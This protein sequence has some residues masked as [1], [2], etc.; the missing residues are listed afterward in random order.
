MER[1]KLSQLKSGVVFAL[2]GLLPGSI[3]FAADEG[4]SGLEEIYVTASKRSETLQDAGM[5][6]TALDSF[7]LER[8]GANTFLDF[9]VRVPNLG[10]AYEADGRFDSNSPAIRGVFGTDTT[11]FY[12]DD[13]P[14][15]ASILPRVMDLERIEVLRGPQGSLYGARSMGGTI[16]MITKQPNLNESEVRLHGGSSTVR[17]GDL[18]YNIDGIVNIP[19]IEDVFALRISA[20]YGMNSGVF[21]REYIPSWIETGSGDVR[22]TTAPAFGKNE[23]IDDESYYGGQILG[24]VML[25]D[26]LTLDLKLMGQ[27]IDADGLPFADIDSESTTELRFFDSDE[28]GTDE[29]YVASAA[30]TWETDMG[31]WV[32]T[33]S[34]YDRE[35]D[36]KEEEAAFLHFLFNN[37][38]GIPIDP[39]ESV[40]STVEKYESIEHET[41]FTSSFDGPIQFTAGIFYQD[42]ELDHEYPAALQVGLNDAVNTFVGATIDIAPD[43]LIFVTNTLTETK[44][45]AV[46]GE[47]TWEATDWLAVTAGGRYYKTEVDAVNASDGFANSGP[48]SYDD[49]QD[50]SGFNPKLLVEAVVS[51]NVNVYASGSKGFRVGGINGQLPP[52]LCGPELATLG[53]NP[54]DAIRYETDSLWSYEVG[55]KSTLAD[56]R[57]S[58]NGA[59]YLIDWSDVQQLNRLACG[60][61]FRANA[62]EAESKGFEIELAAAPTD[63]LTL[64]AGVGF[65]DAEI[66][67]AGGVAG[68]SKGDAIQGVPD[69]TFT[70]SMQ[71]EF[72]LSGG[73]QG[74]V[75]LDGN[76]YGESFSANNE[77]SAVTQRKR[78]A[79]SAL[80]VKLG[81]FNEKWD[82]TFFA[83]NLTDTR[84]NLAD[85]RS[86]AA[87]TPGRQ[88][89]VTNRPRTV[90]IDFRVRM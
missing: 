6:I 33:T 81:V 37:V 20:Y 48:S 15:N 18:N 40:L 16:R 28:P 67:D 83:D 89:L 34:F 35:T 12:I 60:F 68:V 17:D 55:I 3:A 26:N 13:T 27:K 9:A 43:D 82:I 50:E 8:M 47:V 46:F 1:F 58:L 25:S 4:F 84:A 72:D 24:K 32:S 5:S 71:Y 52:G 62:G 70:A 10:F 87:E 49:N 65:T 74:L 36:E 85:S 23:N 41:R 53:V 31:T 78:D 79:W 7:E 45:L 22:T 90:G 75:R 19:V 88:R 64:A 14:V 42:L 21:D 56:N 86:I 44:E 63:G 66:T 61:Q 59:V 69:W 29:W 38:I 57:V 73:W 76:H 51:D 11:G 2:F 54:A 80:N 77:A 39:L 30:F